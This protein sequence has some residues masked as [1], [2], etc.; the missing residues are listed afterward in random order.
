MD[1]CNDVAPCPACQMNMTRVFT[2]PPVLF[3]SDGFHATD[4]G[5]GNVGIGDNQEL[6][7][8]QYERATGEKAPPPA[9]DVPKNSR[10]KY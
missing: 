4:Y 8:K 3:N 1:N 2:A 6:I 7:R 9:A 10:D 5:K